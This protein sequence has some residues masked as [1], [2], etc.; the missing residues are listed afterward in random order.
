MDVYTRRHFGSSQSSVPIKLTCRC[1]GCGQAMEH[2]TSRFEDHPHDDKVVSLQECVILQL[3]QWK[4]DTRKDIQDMVMEQYRQIWRRCQAELAAL[5]GE[6]QRVKE[7]SQGEGVG[8]H[9]GAGS[10]NKHN[11]VNVVTQGGWQQAVS[12]NEASSRH[13]RDAGQAAFDQMINSFDYASQLFNRS[14]VE[15]F[16]KACQNDRKVITK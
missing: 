12:I 9:V 16:P 13:H 2:T 3:E 6:L 15:D 10:S 4:I 11:F 8:V 14:A 1:E 7:D 5:R